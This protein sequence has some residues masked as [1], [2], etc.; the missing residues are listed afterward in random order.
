ML[1]LGKNRVPWFTDIHERSK[2]FGQSR[3]VNNWKNSSFDAL[4]LSKNVLWKI[5]LWPRNSEKSLTRLMFFFSLAWNLNTFIRGA[6]FGRYNTGINLILLY[7]IWNQINRC[8]HSIKSKE[9]IL[10]LYLISWAN[11]FSFTHIRYTRTKKLIA[12]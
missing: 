8:Y 4:K 2:H 1:C 10:H 9:Y 7:G 3:G 5:H 6:P 12:M 11:F